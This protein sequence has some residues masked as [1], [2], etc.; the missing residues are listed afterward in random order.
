[1]PA[2]FGS[3]S[4]LYPN[5][6]GI[7]KKHL[8][9]ISKMNIYRAGMKEQLIVVESLLDQHSLEDFPRRRLPL[10]LGTTPS[11]GETSGDAL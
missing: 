1:M 2:A 6:F 9:N 3:S 11:L 5:E 7:K 10:T 8:Y 4:A